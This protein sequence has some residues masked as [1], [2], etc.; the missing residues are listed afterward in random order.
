MAI[1]PLSLLGLGFLLGVRHA[2][3]ADHVAAVS[4]IVSKHKSIKISSLIGMFWGLGH[5]LSLLLVGL[6]M[7]VFKIAIPERMALSFEFIVGAMLVLL[8]VNVLV[9]ISKMHLH[10]HGHGKGK[11]THFHSH[12]LTKSHG[13][14]HKLLSQSLFVGLIHGLAGSAA[15][16]LL[17]LTA[18]SSVWVGIA[19]I[20]LFGIG[21]VIG[22]ALISSIL[23]LPFSLIPSEFE[24]IQKML[25]ISAGLTSAIM[26]FFIMYNIGIG[27]GLLK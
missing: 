13:H 26:G 18:I 27:G 4:A 10:R 24:R 23:S 15:I 3:D 16:A 7:L 22:M 12:M 2:F 5:T 21:S 9:T 11:H 14:A 8:G 17:V 1:I 20:L 19:Y 25:S 6:V